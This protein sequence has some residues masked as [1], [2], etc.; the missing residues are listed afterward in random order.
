MRKGAYWPDVTEKKAGRFI[1]NPCDHVMFSHLRY[2]SATVQPQT[3]TGT[4][5]CALLDLNSPDA[6]ANRQAIETALASIEAQLRDLQNLK[7]TLDQRLAAGQIS[8]SQHV[9]ES[10]E[11][12]AYLQKLDDATKHFGG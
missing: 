3:A 4:F 11:V 9:T 2:A 7:N 12:A 10:Q 5:V 1:P 8:Q 6:V